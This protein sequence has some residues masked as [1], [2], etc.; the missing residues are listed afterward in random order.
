M[1]S[2]TEWWAY[3]KSPLFCGM[4][5]PLSRFSLTFFKLH[6]VRQKNM[7]TAIALALVALL[8]G[9]SHIS[10]GRYKALDYARSKPAHLRLAEATRIPSVSLSDVT[11][12]QVAAIFYICDE[13][14]PEYQNSV[15]LATNDQAWSEK[16]VSLKME[17]VS[18]ARLIDEVCS[19]TGSVWH[20]DREIIIEKKK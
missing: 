16:R 1:R 19:Q 7:K 8:A 15:A 4:S 10:P 20:A 2:D 18:I 13:N 9:C 11:L 5:C 12:E 3:P 14:M 17:D 6:N